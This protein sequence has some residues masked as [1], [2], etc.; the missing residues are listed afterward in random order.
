M[1]SL[2][3]LTVTGKLKLQNRTDKPVEQ[4]LL[5]AGLI[6]ASAQQDD[7]IR[8]FHADESSTGK[9]L[10]DLKP[11]EKRSMAFE[12]SVPLSDLPSFT[13][14]TQRLMVPIV[15]ANLAYG[16]G[17]AKQI[18]LAC[19]VGREANPPQ[20]KMGPIRLDLGPRSFAGLGQRPLAA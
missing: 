18:E 8:A 11:G 19:M 7:L 2:A 10:P 14:G 12:L 1:L 16:K 13:M 15:L 17:S 6:G 20:P 9:T 4:L 5:R 3:K